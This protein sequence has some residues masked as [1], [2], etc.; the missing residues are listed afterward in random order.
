[1]PTINIHQTP[2][3]GAVHYECVKDGHPPVIVSVGPA[4]DK[5]GITM[6][7]FCN[8]DQEFKDA[9]HADDVARAIATIYTFLPN[10]DQ[11]ECAGIAWQVGLGMPPRP[12]N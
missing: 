4:P 6:I 8:L 3:T 5:L 2:L 1:M 9:V 12:A 10:L 7:A 11:E